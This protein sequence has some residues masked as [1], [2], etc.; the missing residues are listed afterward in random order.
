VGQQEGH[1]RT[2]MSELI[3]KA[4]LYA[5]YKH[6][7][8]LDDEGKSYFDAHVVQVFNIMQRVTEDVNILCAS[9][10]HDVLEDT[11]A[12]YEDLKYIFNEKIA[13]LVLELTK[14]SYNNF[15]R[16][17]SKEAILIKFADRLSNLSRMKTWNK[18]RQEKYI[19]KSKFWK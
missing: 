12:T 19:K 4:L 9:I 6:R 14:E 10:L 17:K 2:I 16:L 3:H 11:N 15:P 18:K 8:V 5:K 7:G 13:D 1:K